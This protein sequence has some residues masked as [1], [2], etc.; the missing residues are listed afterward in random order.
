MKKLLTAAV[1]TFALSSANAADI[2]NSAI[3]AGNF[4]TLVTALKAA[5][6]VD[7]LKGPGPFTVFAP[8]DEAFAK[9]PKATLDA[10]L[11]DK[12]KLANILKYHVVSGKVMAMDLKPGKVKTLEGDSIMITEKKGAFKAN[13]AKILTTD[14]VTDNGVIH[15]IDTV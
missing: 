7:T 6:L 11:K 15:V 1:L 8:T 5:D 9:L 2:V 4:K 12:D 10:L 13:N 14:I 3:D